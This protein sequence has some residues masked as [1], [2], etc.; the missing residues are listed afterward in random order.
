M[1]V[2]FLNQCV[3]FQWQQ[4]AT[5][6]M[7]YLKPWQKENRVKT[8][9]KWIGYLQSSFRH[10]GLSAVK[11]TFTPSACSPGQTTVGR[12]QP[13]PS[14]QPCGRGQ[15]RQLPGQRGHMLSTCHRSSSPLWVPTLQIW[16]RAESPP[17]ILIRVPWSTPLPSFPKDSA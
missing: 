4:I 13:L 14:T 16:N 2:A 8:W 1:S 10:W 15:G 12:P 17:Y 7:L 3:L 9:K 11:Q 5:Q 6:I